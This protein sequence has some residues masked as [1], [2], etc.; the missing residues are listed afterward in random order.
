M[1]E[2][3]TNTIEREYVIPL[4]KAFLRVPEYRRAGR[5]AKTI[6]IFIA[7]HMK[8]PERDVDN[9]KLDMYLN[10]EIWFRGKT[11]PPTKIK[12]KAT[13]VGDIV[14]V[15]FVE[16]PQ[17]VKF[18]KSKHERMH[19]EAEKK[20]T[21][22]E[23]PTTTPEKTESS[24][25]KVEEKEKGKAVEQEQIKEAKKEKLT[26]KHVTKVKEAEIKR[27]ALNRH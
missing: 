16:T 12:V 22:T 2:V 27:T 15:E 13:K 23:A 18:L 4:R 26:D 11:N 24:E 10:N 3:K 6:K 25:K 20:E 17:H 9:V 7:K 8:V 5:A 21:K 1:A 14:K 19:K